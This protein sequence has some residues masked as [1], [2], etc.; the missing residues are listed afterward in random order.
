VGS[1]IFPA[2][3]ETEETEAQTRE[4]IRD[5]FAEYQRSSIIVCYPGLVPG[6]TWWRERSRYGF[7][8]QVPEGDYERS[9]MRYKIRHIL[10]PTLWEPLSYSLAGRD[11]PSIARETARL[12]AWA[13]EQ[14]ICINLPDYDAQVGERLGFEP[15][16]FKQELRRLFFTG[17]VAGLQQLVARANQALGGKR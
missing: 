12:Q 4:M 2:P 6:T 17:D 10:P 7:C 3:F 11:F 16:A 5:V 15:S 14:G 1:F 8:L 13:A 9:I